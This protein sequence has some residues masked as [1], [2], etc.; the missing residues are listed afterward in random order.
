MVTDTAGG[1]DDNKAEEA[2]LPDT[3]AQVGAR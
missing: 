1:M 2:N 3:I